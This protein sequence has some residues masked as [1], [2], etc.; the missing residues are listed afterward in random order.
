MGRCH[1]MTSAWGVDDN[2]K[3]RAR[4]QCSNYA[5]AYKLVYKSQVWFSITISAHHN[6]KHDAG[7]L[8]IENAFLHWDCEGCADQ[9]ELPRDKQLQNISYCMKIQTCRYI[10]SL[11]WRRISIQY[12]FGD[13]TLSCENTVSMLAKLQPAQSLTRCANFPCKAGCE[14][15]LVHRTPTWARLESTMSSTTHMCT[16][17]LYMALE[18]FYKHNYDMCKLYTQPIRTLQIVPR[19]LA[20]RKLCTLIQTKRTRSISLIH[21]AA[22]EL[23]CVAFFPFRGGPYLM[24]ATSF[25]VSTWGTGAYLRGGTPSLRRAVYEQKANWG[26][27]YGITAKS[28]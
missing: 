28:R 14:Q 12:S 9:T 8:A 19:W 6:S 13:T 17:K 24:V 10:F 22:F 11:E 1:L 15:A 27:V 16:W 25:H 20:K 5:A 2:T 3:M 26:L 21:Y 7:R 18:P 23:C 4:A